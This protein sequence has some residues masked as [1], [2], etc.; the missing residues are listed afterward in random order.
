M[1]SHYQNQCWNLVNKTLRNKLQLI[2]CKNSNIFIKK[3]AFDSVVCEKTAILSRPQWVNTYILGYEWLVVTDGPKAD[4]LLKSI[5]TYHNVVCLESQLESWDI[6]CMDF[7][8]NQCHA[9]FFTL[10]GH[11][12]LTFNHSSAGAAYIKG[13]LPKGPYLPCISMAGRA[14]L[15][16]YHRCM[17]CRKCCHCAYIWQVWAISIHRAY[18]KGW[19]NSCFFVSAGG[20]WYWLNWSTAINWFSND[21][22]GLPVKYRIYNWQVPLNRQDSICWTNEHA[23]L[24]YTYASPS[25]PDRTLKI[26]LRYFSVIFDTIIWL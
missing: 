25:L 13:I 1:P 24:S 12:S 2:F 18:Y 19:H 7:Q 11:A 8:S 10:T 3:N 20:L 17:E 6:D 4:S 9:L 22:N 14:L 26:T 23:V 5:A 16:G 15:A 21:G